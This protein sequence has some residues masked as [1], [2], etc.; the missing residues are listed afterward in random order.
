MIVSL[1]HSGA[2]GAVCTETNPVAKGHHVLVAVPGIVTA[3][4][5]T[6][7]SLSVIAVRLTL[8]MRTSPDVSLHDVYEP[9]ASS[10]DVVD[11]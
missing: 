5:I 7:L 4:E 3:I 8:D 1:T 6:Q 2:N 10:V 9:R 11:L